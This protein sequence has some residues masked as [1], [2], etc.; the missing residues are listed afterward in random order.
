[1]LSPTTH[2]TVSKGMPRTHDT[3]LRLSTS[4]PAQMV[5][6]QEEEF[7]EVPLQLLLAKA[8]PEKFAL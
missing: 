5:T 4:L 7:L 6:G 1:M 2:T 3:L 8:T